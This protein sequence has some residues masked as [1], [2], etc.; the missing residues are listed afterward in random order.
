MSTNDFKQLE[1][2]IKLRNKLLNLGIGCPIIGPTGPKGDIGPTGPQGETGSILSSSTE[3]LFSA[4]LL[5]TRSA[6]QMIYQDVWL[7]PSNNEYFS[8]LNENDLE[9]QPGI[10]EITFSGQIEEADDTHG[11]TFYLQT[12]DGA[13]IKDLTFK[14]PINNGKQMHFSQTIIFRFEDVTI[15]QVVSDILGDIG[16]SNIIFTDINLLM[17]KIHE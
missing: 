3:G 12:S 5:D 2:N 8:L 1:E 11:A 13:A 16:T 15:L 17:K 10:Y 6:G 14:L 9:V 7:I 4:C